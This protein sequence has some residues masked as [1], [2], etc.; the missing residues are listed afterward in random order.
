MIFDVFQKAYVIEDEPYTFVIKEAGKLFR[1]FKVKLR[2]KYLKD[3]D[4]NVNKKSLEKYS[5]ITQE[6]WD[7]FVVKCMSDDFQIILLSKNY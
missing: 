7:I 3:K 4:G 2:S 6:Q 5:Y 1:A